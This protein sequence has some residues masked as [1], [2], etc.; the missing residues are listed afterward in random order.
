[1]TSDELLALP[2]NVAL[3]VLLRALCEV[4]P[5]LV[6]KLKSMPVPEVPKPP[7][8]DFGILRKDGTQWAS[9]T[10]LEG[11]LF[12]RAFYQKGA[13]KG[14]Q[15]AA[16]D[17]KRCKQLDAFIAWRR[18]EPTAPWSGERGNEALTAA[19]PSGRPRVHP[20]KQQQQNGSGD[21]A[22]GFEGDMGSA[23]TSGESDIPY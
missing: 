17:A 15:Y 10:N 6:D 8:Y 22:S 16:K 19:A 18:V 23:G 14:G 4:A 11:L 3:R 2:P 9:E 5:E 13:D 21:G 12:W 1:M 20:R 7:R